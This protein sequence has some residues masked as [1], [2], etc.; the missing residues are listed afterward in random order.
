MASNPKNPIVY[1]SPLGDVTTQ[2]GPQ[3]ATTTMSGQAVCTLPFNRDPVLPVPTVTGSKAGNAA[4]T[5]LLAALVSLGYVND[6]TS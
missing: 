3:P 6:T 2:Y 4:L 5:S 1:T